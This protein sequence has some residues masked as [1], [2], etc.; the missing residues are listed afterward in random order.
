MDLDIAFE[1]APDGGRVVTE[2]EGHEAELVFRF[3]GPG[4][5]IAAHTRV[6]KALEGR[7]IGSAL[8]KALI[9]DARA[10]GYQI[11]PQCSF[12]AAAFDRHPEWADLRA[13]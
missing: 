11:V 5:V 2:A 4:R 1:D 9:A 7:G 13:A 8:V 10:E 3:D 6:P 12:V